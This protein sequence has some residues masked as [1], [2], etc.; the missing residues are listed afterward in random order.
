MYNANTTLTKM[1]KLNELYYAPTDFAI[2]PLGRAKKDTPVNGG[3][4]EKEQSQSMKVI[5][6]S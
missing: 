6:V 5:E 4:L 1:L 2:T 3:N